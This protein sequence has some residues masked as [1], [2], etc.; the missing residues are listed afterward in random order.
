MLQP[1]PYSDRL[2]KVAACPGQNFL[3]D[4]YVSINKASH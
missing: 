1:H 3:I 4:Y 2:H